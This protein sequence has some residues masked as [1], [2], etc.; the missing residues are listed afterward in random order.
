[1]LT[2]VG[3]EPTTTEFRS[4]SQKYIAKRTKSTLIGTLK[5]KRDITVFDPETHI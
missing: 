3:F 2:W 4:Y 1:M 5:S